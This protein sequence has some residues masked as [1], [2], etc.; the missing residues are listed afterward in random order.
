[1]QLIEEKF[2]QLLRERRLGAN[3]QIQEN[4]SEE[5]SF[6]VPTPKPIEMEKFVDETI[7]NVSTP[8]CTPQQSREITP[9]PIQG[10]IY[11][12]K[13]ADFQS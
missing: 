3:D 11:N 2:R 9:V 6:S 13:T 5:I 4:S 12:K 7:P 1:M 8:E 10:M